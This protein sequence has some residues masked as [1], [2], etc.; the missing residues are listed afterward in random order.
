MRGGGSGSSGSSSLLAAAPVRA[1]GQPAWLLGDQPPCTSCARRRNEVVR[2]FRAQPVG[3]G[4]TAVEI[5]Q[6][7]ERR[8]RRQLV[9]D[10]VR[11]RARNRHKDG[12]R[13]ERIGDDRLG[14]R[15]RN[16]GAARARARH[17]NRPHGRPRPAWA[18]AAGRARRSC[19]RERFSWLLSQ[20]VNQ[21]PL[22]PFPGPAPP[23][24]RASR[25]KW[26]SGG[27]T[28]PLRRVRVS[29]T[30]KHGGSGKMPPSRRLLLALLI[31]DRLGEAEAIDA[32]RNAAVDQQS[33][34]APRATR[35][36]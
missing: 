11:F 36:A 35:W 34:S 17:P 5:A 20:G 27:E 21:E 10:D 26:R 14:A 29:R 31:D 30:P 22:L 9:D 33:G 7:C 19:Q 2:S 6:I 8:E 1:S 3:R 12:G 18:S 13:I 4:K 32:D 28:P 16:G 23:G 15:R 25:L 24:G